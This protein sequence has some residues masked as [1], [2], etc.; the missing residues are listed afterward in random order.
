MKFKLLLILG[1][2]VFAAAACNK[3]TANTPPAPA[4]AAA[5]QVEITSTESGFAPKDITIKK[6]GTVTFV[7]K[8]SRSI[9]PASDPHPTHTDYSAFDSKKGIE[10]GMTWSFTFQQTGEWAYHDHLSS[11]RRG[12]ITVTE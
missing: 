6:G 12:T 1:A 3:Q 7:N 11:F 5:T 10:P 8:G 4:P 9:W 2:F